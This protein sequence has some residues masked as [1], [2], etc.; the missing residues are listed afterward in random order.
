MKRLISIFLPI[1]L[2]GA[3][4]SKESPDTG[5]SDSG[6]QNEDK[7]KVEIPSVPSGITNTAAT[8]NSLSFEWP[9]VEEP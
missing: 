2:L 4:G 9:M 6:R 7:P 5:G 3:C 1:V 8:D